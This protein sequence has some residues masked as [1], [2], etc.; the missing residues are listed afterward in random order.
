MAIRALQG[1]FECTISPGFILVVGS[2]YRT[3]EHSSRALFW[4]S[5][6][7]G[8]GIISNLV[9]YGIGSHAEK[10][11]GLAPWRCIS[12]FLGACTIVL[13]LICF[14]LLGSPKEVMWMSKAGKR[15]A[16]HFHHIPALTTCLD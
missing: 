3:E 11:G 2:W 13:A 4:Q 16:Y 8:F 9:L 15:M 14:V 5:A 10:Y 1:F 12:L 7:A 6:N